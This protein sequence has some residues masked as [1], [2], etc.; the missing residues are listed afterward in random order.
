LKKVLNLTLSPNVKK[1][2]RF[3]SIIE[4]QRFGVISIIRLW[5]K[6]QFLRN[7]LF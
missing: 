6:Y 2:S 1:M 5:P 4:G 3:T 7:T